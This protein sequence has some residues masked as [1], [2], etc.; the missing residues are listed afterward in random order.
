MAHNKKRN[1]AVLFEILVKEQAK[2][3]LKK[4]D[5][6][7]KFIEKLIKKFYC[8]GS[9]LSQELELY[10]VLSESSELAENTAERLIFNIKQARSTINESLLYEM[11][12]KLISLINKTLGPE[13]FNNFIPNYTKLATINTLFNIKESF[14]HKME[15]EQILKDSLINN[16]K[17]E[18]L[19]KEDVNML[20]FKQYMTHY[21]SEYASLLDEQKELLN[22][23]V[24]Y[25]F[26]DD[27]DLKVYLNT[28]C[29]RLS[30]IITDNI[31]KASNDDLLKEKLTK[32]LTKL[33]NIS[34]NNIDDQFIYSIMKYQELVKEII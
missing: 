22:K 26:G 27:V 24:L 33:Q 14:K 1:T 28:E 25:K 32:V 30:N 23:F 7:A 10:N 11:Q 13:T 21:N 17:E 16:H 18:E 2:C 31:K 4:Q 9:P 8:K 12:S 20:V 5:K 6:K 34:I 3:I 29:L 19:I 15:M